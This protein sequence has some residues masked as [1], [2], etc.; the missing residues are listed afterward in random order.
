MVTGCWSTMKS[1]HCCV[2]WLNGCIFSWLWKIWDFVYLLMISQCFY[3]EEHWIPEA[4]N[5]YI[6]KMHNWIS[7]N[8]FLIQWKQIYWTSQARSHEILSE[9][10]F[11]MDQSKQEKV[12]H[13]TVRFFTNY[14]F[15]E[16]SKILWLKNFKLYLFKQLWLIKKRL[17]I[18][19]KKRTLN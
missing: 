3:T 2:R 17:K 15:L 11:S 13:V 16:S 18:I 1:C 8:D 7:A 14:S 4:Q 6:F 5:K 9:V 19:I 12:I 10:Q